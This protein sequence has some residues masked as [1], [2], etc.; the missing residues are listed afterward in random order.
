MRHGFFASASMGIMAAV[1]AVVSLASGLLAG[2]APTV[3]AQT[4]AAA[5][6]T[7][8]SPRTPWG[9]L[10]LQGIWT[11]NDAVGVSVERPSEFGERE[12]L[13]DEEFV[14]SDKEAERRARDEKA[15]RRPPPERTGSGPEH[16]YERGKTLKQTSL[17]V[18][19]RDGR[20]P[21]TPEGEK[22]VEVRAGYR[23][24]R[25]DGPEERDAWARCITR[26]LPT[27]MTPTGYNNG[28]RILQTPGYVVIHSEMIHEVR[29][30][31]LDGHPHVDQNIGL[32][33]GD[34]RGRWEGNTLVVDT[35]NFNDWMNDGFLK[36]LGRFQG[37]SK[38]MHLVE[39]FTRINAE[40]I[41]Y[42]AT[43]DDPKTFTRP[44]TLALPLAK[45]DG[46]QIFEYACHEGNKALWNMLSGSR[47]EDK[48][49]EEAAKKDRVK[50]NAR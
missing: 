49:D 29:F 8:T 33:M 31:P 46:Y 32:W 27:V 38:N 26:G 22:I 40:T 14:A 21:F 43:I 17:V 10:D 25:P 45:D 35:T 1:I 2:Q 39:R 11:S 15:E 9:D 7:W 41:Q 23:L 30:I 3:A 19:P 28:Y 16:W 12:T 5:K 18:D 44:W 36:P 4:T 6:T 42:E 34:S 24:R 47:A 13:S 50:V 37:A 20:I 48:A